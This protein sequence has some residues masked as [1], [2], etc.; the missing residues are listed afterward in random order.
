M[1]EQKNTTHKDW[2]SQERDRHSNKVVYGN[3]GGPKKGGAGG[4]TVWGKGGLDDLKDV[5]EDPNDPNYV[6]DEDEK[7]VVIETVDVIP[8]VV[9]VLREYFSSGEIEEALKSVKELQ[10]N[11]AEFV[12]KALILAMEKQ[13]FERELTSQLLTSLSSI[14][15]TSTD[16]ETGFQRILDVIDDV[17]LD[18]PD[19][20][21]VLSK[22]IARAI[23]DEVVP[24]R[25]LKDVQP[26]SNNAKESVALASALTTEKH[27]IDRLAHV[28]GPG[29]LSSVKRLKEETNTLLQEYL[30]SSDLNEADRCVRKLNAPSFHFQIVKQAL[31]IALER[32]GEDA[33]KIAELLAFFYKSGLVSQDHTVKGFHCVLDAL[34]D[35][36]LDFPNAEKQLQEISAT[37]VNGGWLPQDW[38]TLKK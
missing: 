14:L 11:S 18:C 8:P 10:I 31:R 17:V 34:N 21:E 12:K 29:D 23:V 37:A 13:A 36:K 5:N 9:A 28:W 26:H 32:D 15:M 20:V 33:K 35:F 7:Q 24:P 3:Q 25:F 6:S 19:A 38:K 30:S 16:I 22:F 1:S 27:R 2:H 4:K